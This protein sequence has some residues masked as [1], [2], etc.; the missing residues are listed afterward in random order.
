MPLETLFLTA[1][2]APCDPKLALVCHPCSRLLDPIFTTLLKMC[3]TQKKKVHPDQVRLLLK[4]KG[5]F[6]SS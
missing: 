5:H 6:S 2:G 1:M 4:A 3:L